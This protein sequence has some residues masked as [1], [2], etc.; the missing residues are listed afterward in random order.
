MAIPGSPMGEER[1]L[2]FADAALIPK[3]AKRKMKKSREKFSSYKMLKRL[4]LVELTFCWA[5]QRREFIDLKTKYPEL[6]NWA[7]QLTAAM[8]SI[9][10]TCLMHSISPRAYLT[11]YLT[12]CAKRGSTPSGGEIELFLPPKLNESIKTKL[13]SFG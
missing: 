2:I 6:S 7:G 12:E 9:I 3:V 1:L 8:F 13:E 10:Q 11:Y 4:G 5:H